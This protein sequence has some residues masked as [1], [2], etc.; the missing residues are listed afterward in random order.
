M[1]TYSQRAAA[2]AEIL[3]RVI[4]LSKYAVT[5]RESNPADLELAKGLWCSWGDPEF[6]LP[7][8][9]FCL[10]A[11]DDIHDEV[12]NL[13]DHVA[14]Y[15]LRGES[16]YD[17]SSASE[18]PADRP[19]E[20][21][22]FFDYVEDLRAL[23]GQCAVTIMPSLQQ[24]KRMDHAYPDLELADFVDAPQ[25]DGVADPSAGRI[26]VSAVWASREPRGACLPG[27][28]P[29]FRQPTSRRTGTTRTRISRRSRRR[30]PGGRAT[31][32]RSR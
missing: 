29:W 10:N 20:Y 22:F 2:I 32:G 6:G 27:V 11:V 19:D 9:T 8:I 1:I 13:R 24:I 26:V 30:R 21:V 16:H 15:P 4:D 7:R 12:R 5:T 28:C 25:L 17:P 23:V 14:A 18:L 31:P 3:G